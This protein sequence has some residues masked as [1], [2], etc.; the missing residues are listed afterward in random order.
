M[1]NREEIKELAGIEG[2]GSYFVSMFLNVN[3]VSNPGGEFLISLKN[4]L[5]EAEAKTEKAVLK[6]VGRDLVAIDNFIMA[7]KRDFKKSVVIITSSDTGFWREYRLNV[8]LKN[9]I[10]IAK[11][12]FIKPLVDIV[13]N[14]PRYVVL[15]VDKESAR[16]FVMQL[17]EL[18]EYGEVHTENIPGRHK[19]GGWFALSQNHFDR[20][21]D[22][23][24][25]LHLKDVMTELESFVKGEEMAGIALCGPEEAVLKTKDLLPKTVADKLIGT[26]Q[27]SMTDT[28]IDVMK[29]AN[30][31]IAVFEKKTE[32]G[33][34]NELIS[35]A[36][37][38]DRAVTGIDKVLSAVQDGRARKV[39]ILRDFDDRGLIC[40]A[41]M[42]LAVDPLNNC[43]HCK[44]KMD[45]TGSFT[46]LLI[47]R[48][49]EGG[50]SVDVIGSSEALKTVG[51]IGA[52]L[53]F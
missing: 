39:L 17:G 15:L 49:V 29:K 45:E 48:A 23:H 42:A 4:M 27:A 34:V 24:V 25:G 6:K 19:K 20:H 46:D 44:S 38:S 22:H 10:I 5:K 50:A 14:Y 37:K 13:D 2:N 52:F 30:A 33:D 41:C 16:I 11:T 35:R 36:R 7:N 40:P 43:P 21:I 26:F 12:P 1:L 31:T 32:T 9:E 47:Q 51:S 3:P 28:N 8:P 18:T 53:R